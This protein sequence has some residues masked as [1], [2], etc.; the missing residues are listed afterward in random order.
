MYEIYRKQVLF[1][2]CES[3]YASRKL[4]NK[5]L[6]DLKQSYP[7]LKDANST[8][9]QKAYDN[10]ITAYKMI[11]KAN[12]GWVHFKSRKNPV[13]TFRTI[14]VKI[15]DGKLKI[16]KC[17]PIRIKYSRK[18]RGEILTATISRNNINQYYVSINVKNSPVKPYKKTFKQVG[19]DLGLKDAITLSNGYK[20]GK[21]LL[22]QIDR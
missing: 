3:L 2:T 1:Y 8:A 16:P 12:H 5:I 19:L 22:T 18:I 17:S 11:G 20:T 15:L 6:N 21:I 10:L 4:F 7:F 13:Q 9:L 14:N